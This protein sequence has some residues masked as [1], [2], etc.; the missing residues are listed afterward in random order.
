MS[1]P[2][3]S[4]PS[5]TNAAS[6]FPCVL[7]DPQNTTASAGP[8][9]PVCGPTFSDS[10]ENQAKELLAWLRAHIPVFKEALPLAL[11]IDK[12]ILALYPEIPRAILL[13]ALR[14]HV[15]WTPY[16]KNTKTGT[17]RV[18]LYG[19]PA[20]ALTEA[21]R[22]HAS[23]VLLQREEKHKEDRKKKQEAERKMRQERQNE[24][25]KQEKLTK[26]VEQFSKPN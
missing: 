15:H 16:L 23:E 11:R 17:Q 5:P 22:A 26:L 8:V 9:L 7:S 6:D 21:H 18:D 4:M 25:R 24:Q 14:I 13:R 3:S 2:L 1:D 19:N 20:G 10:T 12:A